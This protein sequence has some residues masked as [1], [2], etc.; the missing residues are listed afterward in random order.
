MPEINNSNELK[1]LVYPALTT[2]VREMKSCG[3]NFI[4][5]DDIWNLLIE[6][7]WKNGNNI[8]LCDIVDD[9]LNCNNEI[10]YKSYLEK[11]AS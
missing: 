7:F 3:Y 11:K 1:N 2:K 5:Q 10:I 4:T 6:L 9:I 8:A